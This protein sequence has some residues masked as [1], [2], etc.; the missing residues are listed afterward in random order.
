METPGRT[1]ISSRI[2]QAGLAVSNGVAHPEEAIQ[3]HRQ[4][5]DHY[6]VVLRCGENGKHCAVCCFEQLQQSRI[7]PCAEIWQCCV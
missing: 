4:M 2:L 3:I 6:T 1:K 7:A 5:F